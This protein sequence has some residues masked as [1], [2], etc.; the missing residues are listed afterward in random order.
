MKKKVAENKRLSE[1]LKEA[2]EEV[3]KLQKQVRII[4]VHSPKN[5]NYTFWK[6]L[7]NC[8]TNY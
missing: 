3:E 7:T 5:M 2:K 1:S 4:D 6:M 8:P